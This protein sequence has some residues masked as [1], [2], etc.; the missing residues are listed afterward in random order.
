MGRLEMSMNQYIHYLYPQ[1]EQHRWLPR[2][3]SGCVSP[4]GDE[5]LELYT[6]DTSPAE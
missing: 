4:P 2:P 1:P 5:L 3:L 6:G